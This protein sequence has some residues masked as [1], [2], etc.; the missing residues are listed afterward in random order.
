MILSIRNAEFNFSAVVLGI[1]SD[2]SKE[3][4]GLDDTLHFGIMEG[5]R[6]RLELEFKLSAFACGEIKPFVA[7]ASL[8]GDTLIINNP[9]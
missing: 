3:F 1:V 6:V 5:K 4:S 7:L 8:S 2:P 9:P